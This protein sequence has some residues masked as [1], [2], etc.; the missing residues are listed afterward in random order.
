MLWV[1]LQKKIRQEKNVFVQSYLLTMTLIVSVNECHHRRSMDRT[2][3]LLLEKKHASIMMAMTL[4]I[5][6]EWEKI[7][8]DLYKSDNF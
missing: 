4:K 6:F 7:F 3:T 8:L 1:Y 2:Q 5:F